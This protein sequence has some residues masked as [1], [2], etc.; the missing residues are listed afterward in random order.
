[1]P[2]SPLAVTIP[3]P[4][5]NASASTES[6]V[7]PYEPV[8][9]PTS[10]RTTFLLLLLVGL[11]LMNYVDRYNLPPVADPIRAE[12]GVS[13][14]QIGWLATGFLIV[15]MITAPV[16]GVLADR[17]SRW[18]LIGIGMLIQAAGTFCSGAAS[19]FAMLMIARCIVGIGDAA[20]GPAAPTLIADLYPLEKRGRMMAWFYAALPVGSAIGYGVGGIMHT[21]T[22]G[23][24]G[25]FYV[26][27][28]PMVALGVICLF[29]RDDRIG[30]IRKDSDD[31]HI[32]DP[33]VRR[34]W[35]D[36]LPLLRNPSYLLNCAGMTAMTF[37][38]GGMSYWMPTYLKAERGL[39]PAAADL[40]FG[41]VIVVAGLAATL[42]GGWAGD[43]LKTRHPGSYFLV[44]GGS[45]LIA[46]PLF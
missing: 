28:L 9:A 26:I 30:K 45:M 44:S 27:V 41:G 38:V 1:M 46:V 7:L 21:L 23:W 42:M 35:R 10:R 39:S 36:Y 3:A 2:I 43:K 15:Y 25:G 31:L 12:F 6:T 40:G 16:F 34:S 19:T 33:P 20:Y 13:S 29:L 18:K 14:Q 22:G 32:N 4:M 17:Q 37:A 11:N 8:P 24:R 5:S